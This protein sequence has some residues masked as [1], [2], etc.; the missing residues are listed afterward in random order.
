M[1][2]KYYTPELEDLHIDYICEIREDLEDDSIYWES[3]IIMKSDLQYLSNWITWG[4]L[5]TKYLDKDDIVSLGF[6]ESIDSKD[7]IIFNYGDIYKDGGFLILKENN[8]VKISSCKNI[9]NETV[10]E[11]ECKSINELK[12]V[13]KYLGINNGKKD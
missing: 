8:I 9:Y 5:R 7:Y 6:L 11:G 12:N 10:F 3:Y 2:N 1:E 4:E 13:L